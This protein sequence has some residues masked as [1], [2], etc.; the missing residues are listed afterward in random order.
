MTK[1]LFVNHDAAYLQMVVLHIHTESN[2]N[3]KPLAR[4]R[5]RKGRIFSNRMCNMELL[6]ICIVCA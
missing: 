1:V 6:N 3:L 4:C 5:I 2:I